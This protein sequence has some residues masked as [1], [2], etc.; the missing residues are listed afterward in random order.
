MKL[1]IL[2]VLLLSMAMIGQAQ[3]ALVKWT[4]PA[5]GF[6]AGKSYPI[7]QLLNSRTL[8]VDLFV[9]DA[10]AKNCIP[11]S[12]ALNIIQ[13]NTNNASLTPVQNDASSRIYFVIKG[14][15]FYFNKPRCCF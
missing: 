3:G 10:N 2:S 14:Y 15:R 7:G 11:T 1:R 8:S 9:T 6:M 13:S 4:K 12:T 5:E